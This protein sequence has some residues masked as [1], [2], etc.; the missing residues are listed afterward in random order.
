MN[1]HS[2]GASLRGETPR[3]DA[4]EGRGG[5]RGRRG[6]GGGGGTGPENR[7][8]G[9]MGGI[10]ASG[11][12]RGDPPRP[13]RQL[14][15]FLPCSSFPMLSFHLGCSAS[16]WRVIWDSR[17]RLHRPGRTRPGFLLPRPPPRSSW[18]PRVA[19]SFSL[20]V[21]LLS[22]VFFFVFPRCGLCHRESSCDTNSWR[23]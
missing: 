3:G 20:S 17:P 2:A 14:Q 21:I 23:G 6:L 4:P 8:A 11:Q 16:S 13:K 12:G 15:T 5:C 19:R 1:I 9:R 10:A 7:R 22:G 18:P